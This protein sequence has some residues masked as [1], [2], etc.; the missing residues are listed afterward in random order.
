MTV[1]KNKVFKTLGIDDIYIYFQPIIFIRNSLIIG[2]EALVRGINKGKL[3]SPLILFKEANK[4]NICLEFDRLCRV[5][6]FEEYN[7][8][9][10]KYPEYML[11][12]N[13]D[14]SAISLG[15]KESKET[16]K[17]AESFNIPFQNVVIEIPE[18]EIKKEKGFK[19]FIESCKEYG[20]LIALDDVGVKYSNIDR[21]FEIRPDILKLDQRLIKNTKIEYHK[22]KVVKSLVTL[23]KEIG[24]LTLAEGIETKEEVLETMKLGLDFHQGFLFFEPQPTEILCS[25]ISQNLEYLQ[26]I[27]DPIM[28]CFYIEIIE[29]LYRKKKLIAD[30]KSFCKALLKELSAE[31]K[32]HFEKILKKWI[33]LKDEI[34]GAYVVDIEGNLVTDVILKDGVLKS[35]LSLFKPSIIGKN[36]SSHPYIYP[37]ISGLFNS[38]VTEPYISFATGNV[39]IT[40][41]FLFSNFDEEY[42]LCID[43]KPSRHFLD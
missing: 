4:K 17:I 42:I 3:I 15:E 22:H 16:F 38:F 14:S 28:E 37:I 10:N 5:R 31:P 33:I 29:G 12:L 20:F 8:I 40:I 6:A 25:N 13:F 43:F 30:W 41:S 11:F 34:E 7:K 18:T 1:K 39:V 35:K 9:F 2:L 36:L 32:E 26:K 24:I 19:C 21:I 27:L 23:A